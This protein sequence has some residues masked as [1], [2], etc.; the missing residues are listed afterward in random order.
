MTKSKPVAYKIYRLVDPR[1]SLEHCDYVRY[2]GRTCREPEDR[3]RGHIQN[4]RIAA[5]HCKEEYFNFSSLKIQLVESV[6]TLDESISREHFWIEL[7]QKADYNLLNIALMKGT[8]FP[9]GFMDPA[10][11]RKFIWAKVK[12]TMQEAQD[13]ASCST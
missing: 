5:R 6:D 4:S 10:D 1:Y 3:L 11:I 13:A 8:I 7:H 2:V 12:K 9:D